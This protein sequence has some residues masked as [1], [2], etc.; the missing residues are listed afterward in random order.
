[1]LFTTLKKQAIRIRMKEK[2]EQQSLQT[3]I[4]HENDVVWMDKHEI[5][6]N[7]KMFDISSRTLQNGYYTF[8]GLYDDEETLLVN[9]ERKAAGEN[10]EQ[11]KLL[12][13]LFKYLPVF[14]SQAEVTHDP[15]FHSALNYSFTT[16]NPV[17]QYRE[18]LTPPPNA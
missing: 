10:N 3:V 2:I 7:D 16:Q 12:A 9:H 14:C 8:T 13:Q 6:V 15:V 17:E 1:M 5:W 18:I 11:N 4:V